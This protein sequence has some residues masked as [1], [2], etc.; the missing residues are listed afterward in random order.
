MPG[1]LV[2]V[3]ACDAGNP[4]DPVEQPADEVSADANTQTNEAAGPAAKAVAFEQE[5]D[6]YEF[7][8]GWPARISAIPPLADRLAR[9]RDESLAELKQEAE[10]WQQEGEER[11]FSAPRYAYSKDWQVVTDLPRFLSLSAEVYSYS[12]GAHGMSVSDALV[13]DRE[14]GKALKPSAMFLS[15]GAIDR[16][17]QN[18]FCDELDRQRER[19]RGAPVVRSDDGFN[20]CIAPSANGTLIL[21]SSSGEAFDR[22]G[23]LVPPYNA[24]PYAEGG[25]EVTLPVDAALIDAVKPEYQRFFTPAP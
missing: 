3:A 18:R 16:A 7:S 4:A 13:W 11:G 23:F 14:A 15:D 8:Y 17:V 22:I 20:D 1:A 5:T 2:M 19:K 10:A 12:G 6:A 9:E 24:G 21:G 25:Y